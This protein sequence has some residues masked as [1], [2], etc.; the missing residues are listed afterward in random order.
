MPFISDSSLIC[1]LDQT[2]L[3]RENGSLRCA[4]GH[5]FDI[6]KQGHINLLPVQDKKSRDPGDSREMVDARRFFLQSG[7]YAPLA[8]RLAEITDNAIQGQSR[9]DVLDAGCGDG[10][11]LNEITARLEQSNRELCVT[12][13]DIS[14]WAARAC[15]SRYKQFTAIVASNRKI[16]LQE[17][18]QDLVLCLFGF[19][20]YAE[21]QRV[22]RPGGLLIQVDPG[23][24]H[25]IELRREIYAEVKKHEAPS[26]EEAQQKLGP[27]V[28]QQAL[29]FQSAPLNADQRRQLLL[30]TPHFH[31]ASPTARQRLEQ[32]DGLSVSVDATIRIFRKS[33]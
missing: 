28:F 30:M 15:A 32:K 3:H 19:P 33:P 17:N 29:Q 11:Y 21:F 9:L 14:K 25:L 2:E 27:L 22:L 16:P 7:C 8:Q 5:C 13:L 12:G 23:P 18:S 26:S 6:A 10:Y 4:L 20:V 31:R 24:D 1:P